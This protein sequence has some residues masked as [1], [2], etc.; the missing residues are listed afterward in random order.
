MF[1]QGFEGIDRTKARTRDCRDGDED[2]SLTILVRFRASNLNERSSLHKRNIS[3]EEGVR[4]VKQGGGFWNEVVRSEEAPESNQEASPNGTV[5]VEPSLRCS[6]KRR[7]MDGV[8]G[9][10]GLEVCEVVRRTP[11]SRRASEGHSIREI[12]TLIPMV[13]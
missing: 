2:F 4:G 8:N 7:S 12:L 3:F 5:A 13:A 11:R 9:S 1:K 6:L 10:F